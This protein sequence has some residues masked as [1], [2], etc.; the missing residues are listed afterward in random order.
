MKLSDE[1]L[2]SLWQQDTRAIEKRLDCL[3]S[4]LLVHAGQGKLSAK[5]R[6]RVASHLAA[7]A[8]C[9]EEYRLALLVKEWAIDAAD[10]H[11]TAFPPRPVTNMPQSV[12]TKESRWAWLFPLAKSPAVALAAVL[13]TILLITIGWL[14]WQALQ[15]KEARQEIA[16]TPL[17]PSATPSTSPIATPSLAGTPVPETLVVQLNDGQALITLD[18]QGR[19]E[20]ADTLPPAYQRMVK[21]ALTTQRIER[22]PLLA[23]LHNRASSL[24]GGNEQGH[25]FALTA[26]I[27][28]VVLSERPLF[29][30]TPLAG[31]TG[32][33]VEVYDE[34]FNQ[35]VV[36]PQL[37]ATSWTSSQSLKRG[38]VYA[39]QVRASKDGQEVKAPRPN[40]PDATF[41]VLDQTR[42]NEVEHARRAY[43][44]SHLTLGLIYAQAGL[45]SEAERE[46]RALQTANPQSEVARRLLVNVQTLRR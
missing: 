18:T 16:E 15:K 34:K 35:V 21:D 24:R 2:K 43:A 5:E 27:G 14:A 26:P 13:S 45:L 36:S 12:A 7:C 25:T 11:V 42:T 31:A 30:W 44:T 4:D 6:V 28:K 9:A 37:N 1:E 17:S 8:D 23:A 33:V 46:F 41:R 10:R 32:Y 20:G 19:L 22:S 39:W 38:G 40:A 29:R 3:S